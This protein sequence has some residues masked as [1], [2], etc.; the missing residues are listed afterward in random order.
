MKIKT[1]YAMGSRKLDEQVNRFLERGDIEVVDVRY[2]ASVFYFS[3]LV[4]YRDKT[5][6]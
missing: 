2:G 3:V 1:F 4:L 5:V 6:G